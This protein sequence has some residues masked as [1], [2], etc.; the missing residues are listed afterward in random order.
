MEGNNSSIVSHAVFGILILAAI[1]FFFLFISDNPE[2][3]NSIVSQYGLVGL[4]I[5]AIIAN[6]TI[7]LPV[8]MD[9]LVIFIGANPS[10]VGLQPGLLN[11]IIMAV[12]VGLGA[13]IGELTAYIIGLQGLGI[14]E[15]FGKKQV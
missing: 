2:F 8:P 10:L 7:F 13:A 1:L 14:A 5:A 6:A 3:F 12:I 9:V 15:K 11:Y 4:F